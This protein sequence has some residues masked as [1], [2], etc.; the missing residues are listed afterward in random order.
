VLE[1]Y[2]RDSPI[3]CFDDILERHAANVCPVA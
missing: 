2:L 1:E 3:P